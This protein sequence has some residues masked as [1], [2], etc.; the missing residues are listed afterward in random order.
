MADFELPL[1][2]AKEFLEAPDSPQALLECQKAA[3]ALHD[4][5]CLLLRDPRV[6]NDKNEEFLDMLEDYYSQPLD[7]LLQDARPELGYQIGVSPELTEDPKCRTHSDCQDLIASINPDNRPLPLTQPD[8]KWRFFWRI[9]DVPEDTRFP[10]LNAPA[11]VPPH[12]ERFPKWKPVM[13]DWGNLLHRSGLLVSEMAAM[14]FGLPRDT[15]TNLTQGGPHLLAPTGSDLEKYGQ[16]G[17]VLAGFHYDLNFLTLHGKSRYP[18]L[19]IWPRNQGIKLQVKVPDGCLLVQ[20]GRQ[21]EYLTGGKVLAGYH[22][23]VVTDLTQAAMERVRAIPE[24]QRRPLWRV[25]STF[26][27]HIASDQLLRP[28][29]P[30]FVNSPTAKNYPPILTG[31]YVKE[32]L[33]GIKLMKKYKEDE[34]N[35]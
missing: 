16:V 31:D 28:L 30:D 7:D 4:Y 18:G 11:V 20:T 17:T 27:L 33:T 26:F 3:Q 29:A 21:M 2:E 24:P 25:S 8:P 9:G 32:E 10:R 5:G 22:E 1:V 19:Y 12:R 35:E 6:S 34:G 15:F 23:V 13:D 14:G